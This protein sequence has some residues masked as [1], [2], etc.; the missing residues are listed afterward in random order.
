MLCRLTAKEL[1]KESGALARVR[2]GTK[3]VPKV[4]KVE[5]RTHGRKAVARKEAKGK[6]NVARERPEHV[7]RVARQ[8]TLQL[9]VERVA[10]TICT[11][12]IKTTL[13]T[14]KNQLTTKKI[15]KHGVCWKK[16]NMTNSKR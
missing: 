3:K 7:G 10:T 16:V 6:R 14:P 12:L 15:L 1:A 5:E 8:D 13:K 9:G 2:A 11:P 4:A